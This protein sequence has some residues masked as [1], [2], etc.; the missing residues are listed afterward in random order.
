MSF[1]RRIHSNSGWAVLTA[2]AAFSIS[3]VLQAQV[4]IIQPGAPGQPGRI[5]TAEEASDL[6]NVS[7]SL[8]DIQFLRGMIPHHAQAKEMSALADSRTNH[9]MVLAV[10]ARITL[11]QDDE[12]SMMQGWLRDQG[13]EAP[14]EDVHHQPGFERMEGMLSDEQMATLTAS[15]GPEFNRLYLE[16]MIDHHQGALDMVE[17]LLDQRGSVQDPLLYEFTSDVTS[18][19]T[20]EIE[21]MDLLLASLNPDP[22]VGLAAGFRDAGEAALNMRIVASLPKPAG[23]FDPERPSGLSASRLLELEAAANGDVPETSDEEEED[24]N[25][26]PR[27]ALLSFSNTDLL[28]SGNYM[29]AGN[30]HG[31]N[32][33]DISNAQAPRHIGS[34]VCPGG[35]GDVSLVGNLLIMSVQEVRGRLDCGLQGVPEPVSD[36]RVKGIRIFDV[37]DFTNP[38]Q[39][40]AVQTCRGSHTHTVVSDPTTVSG[41]IY[42]YVSGTSAVRDDE[43]LAGCSNDSPFEDENSALFRIEVIEIPAENPAA[44]RIVNRPFIFADPDSGTLAGLWGGGDHGDD[45]QTTR[46]TNQC[47]DITT[48]PDIG[49]AAGACSGNGIL[50]DISDPTNPERLDQVIDP[51]FSYWH[52]ATFNN[53]GDK[54]IFTDEW[55]GGGRPRCRAQDPLTWGADAFYDIVDGKL[56]FRSHY[57]MSAP[58][59]DTENCVAHNGSLIPVPGRD[60]FVQAWYQGGVSIVDFTDSANPIEIA[61][62]DR[63]PIDEEELITGGYWSTYWYNGHIYGT[64]ISRGLDVFALQSSDYLT[65]N[66]IAAASLPELNGIVNAQT[67]EIVEWP[68]VPVVARAYMD[69]LQREN[70]LT[71]SQASELSDALERAEDLLAGENGNRRS[72]MRALNNLADDFSEVA[73]DYNGISGIRY[74]S[75]AETLEGIADSL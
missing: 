62:F 32:T 17:M 51:G 5:I 56:Q 50:L 69:Q 39:V 64:E 2:L 71:T 14:A 45:T 34:V 35:Q 11:S 59:T 24:E 49:L 6:A 23:F 28:F 52:S 15:S 25:S 26:D 18:D 22:R 10:A 63:G 67:Q 40:A 57:K 42:V 75:L 36:E 19:Q 73:G 4:P 12:I 43:E 70:R 48:F 60:L 8:G 65:E 74:A 44:A 61:F 3:S 21:R 1:P 9:T 72:T 37:S 31:F 20:S 54:V 33:Y 30:Y 47:H 53:R 58:Q 13:L 55:G 29:V 38:I 46:Q 16:Y 66:E 27:P 7:Y 68:A 41:N